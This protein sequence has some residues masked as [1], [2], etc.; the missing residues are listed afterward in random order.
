M[1]KGNMGKTNIEWTGYTWNPWSGC[2]KVSP[3]CKNCYMFS[4]KIR[5]GQ[6]PNVVVRSKTTFNAPLKWK[7]PA[8][9]FTCSWSDWFIEE[10]DPWR[11][12][13][14]DI[15]RRTPHLTYQILT[16]RVDRVKD[17]WWYD[18][19][20]SN[21]WLGVSVEDRKYGLPRIDA[22][23]EL[24]AALRFLSIEPLLEDLGEINLTGIGWVIL[25]GESGA[26]ARPFHFGWAS[27]IIDQCEGAGIPVFVKQIGA[28]P[29]DHLSDNWIVRD[30]KGGDISEW[31]EELRIRQM[32]GRAV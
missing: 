31:P 17:H 14:Y 32:P 6:D 10:A 29:I 9:V 4:D 15:I 30:R 25:G 28:N 18:P 5:Y 2:H 12:E 1:V 16:K 24:P 19:H 26:G 13:A 22:L 8:Y 21:A 11:E 7:D 20:L 27:N 3:G 23:R